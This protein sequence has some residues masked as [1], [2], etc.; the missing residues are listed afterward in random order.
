MYILY[1]S[2]DASGSKWNEWKQF[3]STF[4]KCLHSTKIKVVE[5][6]EAIFEIK[7]RLEGSIV[8]P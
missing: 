2:R 7:G 6:V 8:L 4:L 1:K 3:A 5:R